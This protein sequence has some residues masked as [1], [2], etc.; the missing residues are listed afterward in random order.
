MNL[1]NTGGAQIESNPL[2]EQS[3]ENELSFDL[4]ELPNAGE[5]TNLTALASRQ[6]QLMK[7]LTEVFVKA[8][9]IQ[10]ELNQL[11]LTDI[12]EFM[13]AI[14]ENGLNQITLNGP[15]GE[16]YPIEI[17][18]KWTASLTEAK[19]PD[20]LEWLRTYDFGSLIKR[21]V[22]FKFDASEDGNNEFENLKSLMIE[23]EILDFE[24]SETV[25]AATLKSFIKEQ[26]DAGNPDLDLTLFSAFEV[27]QSVIAGGKL[28]DFKKVK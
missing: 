22:I 2:F 1:F 23:N 16:L 10:K 24:E 3:Q 13:G 7:D 20:A 27:K 17:V 8:K 28:P 12:P 11:R 14:G 25:N 18:K 5:L 9:K 19:K 26:V 4:P 6:V 21:T 15:D